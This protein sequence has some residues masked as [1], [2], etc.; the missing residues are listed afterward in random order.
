MGETT[1]KG[2]C[3]ETKAGPMVDSIVLDFGKSS[4]DQYI[5]KNIEVTGV[6]IDSPWK[7][8]NEQGLVQQGFEGRVM[9]KIS[10]VKV[11]EEG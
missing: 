4:G 10:S 11:I 6:I 8:V 2:K 3:V 9:T 1:I 7:P 5:G